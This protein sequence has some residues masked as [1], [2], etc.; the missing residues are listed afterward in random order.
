LLA[1]HF[2][3]VQRTAFGAGC[4]GRSGPSTRVTAPHISFTTITTT[5]PPNTTAVRNITA[6]KINKVVS[7][8][9]I[10]H[11]RFAA[12]NVICSSDFQLLSSFFYATPTAS[13]SPQKIQY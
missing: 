4:G 6:R 13:V 9:T 5:H 8:L 12:T 2:S 7:T 1:R 11:I 3:F 10:S